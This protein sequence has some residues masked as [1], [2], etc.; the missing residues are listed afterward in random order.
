MH[1]IIDQMVDNYRPEVEELEQ[2]LDEL[3]DRA[4]GRRR[5]TSSARSST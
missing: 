3:E 4:S 2:W 1:R 5:R